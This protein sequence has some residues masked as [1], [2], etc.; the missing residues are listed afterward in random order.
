MSVFPGPRL[1][2]GELLAIETRLDFQGQLSDVA[3]SWKEGE[4]FFLPFRALYPHARSRVPADLSDYLVSPW[5]LE[6]LLSPCGHFRSSA[7]STIV[8][9][10]QLP[11]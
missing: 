2:G 9:E 11:K 4:L 8:T 3:G 5:F 6:E 7:G 1:G 10:C